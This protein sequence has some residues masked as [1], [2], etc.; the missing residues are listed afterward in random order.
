MKLRSRIAAFLLIV[1]ALFATMGTTINGVLK[2]I[3]LGLDLQGGFEVLYEVQPLKDGGKVTEEDVKATAD[4]ISRR[5]NVLGVSEPS[6]QIEG[7]N[8]IRVQ[9]AGVKNQD[10]AREVLSSQANLT[11][12]DFDDKLLLNGNDLVQGG[13]KAAFNQENK[14]IVTLKLKDAQKFADITSE[15]SQRPAPQNLLVIWLDYQKGD[16]Y[17]KEAQKE[18]PAYA[19]AATVTKVLNTTDVE[20]SGNFTVQE[21]KDLAGILNAG[22]LPAK[23]VEMYS[24]S[25]GAQFGDDA[26]KATVFASIIGVAAIFIFM[27]VVYRLPG[28]VAVITLAIFTYIV[29]WVFE[30]INAVLTLPGIA[31]LVLGIGMAV[32]ANI[33]M[34]ERIK[35]ELRVGKSVKAAFKSGSKSSFTAIFDAN[36]TTL[37]AAAVLFYFGTS[38]VKGFATT[39]IISIVVTF[40]TAIA[41]TR[42]LLGLLVQ[43][44]YLDNKP[45]LFGVNKKKVHKLSEGIDTLDLKTHFDRFDFV[46]NRKKFFALSA[47]LILAG[48]IVLGIFKLNLGIDFTAGSRVEVQTTQTLNSEEV[49]KVVEKEGLTPK[50]ISIAGDKSETAVL[51][52]VEDFSKDEVKQFRD[53]MKA[54]YGDD[55]E[56]VISTVS[57]TIGAELVSNAIK[58]LVYAAIG[59]IIYV[60]VRF[61]WR[62]GVGTIISLLHDVFFMIAIF[63][64]FRIEVDITFI[65]AVLTIVGY[66][67]N[68]TIVTFDR[69]RENLHRVGVIKN[70]ED[71]AHIVNK[72]LRQ[73]LT[74]SVNTVVTVLVVV[75]A[76]MIFGATSI[77]TFSLALLIGLVTGVY[78]SIYI[79]AQIWY[80]L[81][82]RQM[83]KQG[84]KLDVSKKESKWGSDEPMV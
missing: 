45:W 55:T 36:I 49:Q 24:T 61:E 33:L 71:L 2:D 50:D 6:I 76:L 10:Q 42:I 84:G 57:T 35:E 16:S 54:Q 64:L 1:I 25:V 37:L 62:M 41:G 11:F 52:F 21:T 77:Q 51:R 38:S 13:A 15:I 14:P 69:I 31:A 47:V 79:A 22:A 3:N 81:K 29:L 56:V 5:V 4:A 80:V 23:L 46:H 83:K 78:S 40:I 65:A 67:I 82:V 17:V 73:T 28:L 72:S 59:I 34:Y 18:E 26:L 19:S 63:S 58:A 9:L 68:D 75:I 8:R 44:G 30:M 74:R 43:S 12:R 60:A 27:L 7:K 66:S 39:L 20:I 70:A 48:M 53:H 32:D